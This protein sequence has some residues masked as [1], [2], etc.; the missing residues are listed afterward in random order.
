MH[1]DD[2]VTV[3]SDAS[4]FT[5]RL[6]F[7]AMSHNKKSAVVVTDELLNATSDKEFLIEHLVALGVSHMGLS[8]SD[9][10]FMMNKFYGLL[11][12]T[13]NDDDTLPNDKI[14][15]SKLFHKDMTIK[16]ASIAEIKYS[17]ADFVGDDSYETIIENSWSKNKFQIRVQADNH[18]KAVGYLNVTEEGVAFD[19][20][21]PAHVVPKLTQKLKITVEPKEAHVSSMA[22]KLP[23]V[24]TMVEYPCSCII[25]QP[26]NKETLFYVIIHLNDS[27]GWTREQI[28]DWVDKLHDDGIINAEF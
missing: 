2:Y 20:H 13:H 28:A 14:S 6:T 9:E 17:L 24:G 27:C 7:Y 21:K 16:A 19:T 3:H 18:W 4:S 1:I 25:S 23:G 11:T 26:S 5:K 12:N 15:K 22:E 10:K 8:E